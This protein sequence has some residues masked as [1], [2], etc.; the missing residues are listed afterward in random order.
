MTIEQMTKLSEATTNASIANDIDT[1]KK[2]W[3]IIQND[4][5][6][7]GATEE[8]AE[9]FLALIRSDQFDAIRN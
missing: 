6:E 9:W 2:I 4:K 7:N 8:G 5:K 1:L 3:T